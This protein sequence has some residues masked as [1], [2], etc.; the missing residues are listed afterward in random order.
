MGGTAKRDRAKSRFRR[1]LCE[2]AYKLNKPPFK[3]SVTQSRLLLSLNVTCCRMLC[4]AVFLLHTAWTAPHKLSYIQYFLHP[5]C[6]GKTVAYHK[7][8][9]VFMQNIFVFC[10]IST[11]IWLCQVLLK[12]SNIRFSKN[13][14]D[15]TPRFCMWTETDRQTGG[16]SEK[17]SR[18]FSQLLRK[19]QTNPFF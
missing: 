6:K 17:V 19:T 16:P 14:P 1:R 9:L 2:G 18:R 13:P 8:T 10:A 5:S 12:T 3:Y 15:G 4:C 7:C 11:K